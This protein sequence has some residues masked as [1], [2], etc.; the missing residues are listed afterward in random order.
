MWAWG[1][2]LRL[3]TQSEL[4]SAERPSCLLR[5]LPCPG[6][7]VLHPPGCGS[8]GDPVPALPGVESQTT[9]PEV[10]PQV[11]CLQPHTPGRATVSFSWK[12][13]RHLC[14]VRLVPRPG[15]ESDPSHPPGFPISW[16]FPE[17]Q[18]L[19]LPGLLPLGSVS[20]SGS[21]PGRA[22]QHLQPRQPSQGRL[23]RGGMW[24]SMPF[25]TSVPSGL[26][27]EAAGFC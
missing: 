21:I 23:R 26:M 4:A 13:G 18:G 20:V 12:W 8:L 17:H 3:K 22:C 1:V 14:E 2:P 11:T 27:G 10:L 24:T 19:P 6:Q 5:V 16:A 9:F 25:S 15:P 7:W